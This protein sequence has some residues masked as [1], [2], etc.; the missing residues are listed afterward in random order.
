MDVIE[1]VEYL[2]SDPWITADFVVG[3][4]GVAT[5]YVGYAAAAAGVSI[6]VVGQVALGIVGLIGGVYGLA[7]ILYP[8]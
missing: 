6:P 7:R 2:T 3:G 8:T 1:K 5:T 4:I